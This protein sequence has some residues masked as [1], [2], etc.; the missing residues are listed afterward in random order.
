[1]RAAS[2]DDTINSL[3]Y[4]KTQGETLKC[5]IGSCDFQSQLQFDAKREDIEE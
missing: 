1:M 4:G 3:L 2:L 5:D